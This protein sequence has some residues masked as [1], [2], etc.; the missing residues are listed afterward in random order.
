M[1]E[2]TP[3]QVIAAGIRSYISS[4]LDSGHRTTPIERAVL[5]QIDHDADRIAEWIVSDGFGSNGI[6]MI[7]VPERDMQGEHSGPE[8]SHEMSAWMLFGDNPGQIVNACGCGDIEIMGKPQS[9][10]SPTAA[11]ELAAALLAAAR[12]VEVS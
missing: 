2:K 5:Q 3:E 12:V 11:R 10:F 4:G 7:Q 8:F 1:S 6:E 9:R